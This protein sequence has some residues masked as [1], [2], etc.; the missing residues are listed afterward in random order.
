MMAPLFLGLD[1]GTQGTKGLLVDAERGEVVAR[2]SVAYGLIEGLAPGACEQHPDTWWAAV[3]GVVAA[4]FAGREGDRARVAGLGVSGQQHGLVALDEREC[5]L[6]PA[7]LWCDT[8]CAVE[9]REL[10]QRL[11]RPIPCG[12]TAPKILWLARHEPETFARTRAVCLPHEWINLRLTSARTAEAGDASGTGFFD[13]HT[14]T[15]DVS[16]ARAIDARVPDMLA[17]LVGADELAGRL[18][19]DAARALGL[20]VG[21]PVS[22]GSGDNMLSALGA[23]ATRPGVAVL[24]LG[25]SGTVCTYS[26]A[27]VI[28][29]T[30]AI[31][32]FCDATGAYLPLLCVMNA[33][34]VTE[35]VRRAFAIDH[36]A[37]A[38]AAETAPAGAR[39][40]LWLPYL[41]GERV[42]D[43][44]Q[45]SGVIAG[46]RTGTLEPGLL[47]RAAI[48]GVALNLA[49]G[50]ER[51]REQGVSIESARLVGGASRSDLWGRILAD[52]LEIP[53]V[54]PLESESAALGAAL[55]ALW[56]VRRAAGEELSAD[57]VAQ[58]FV[59]CEASATLPDPRVRSVYREASGRFR[60]WAVRAFG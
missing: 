60:E 38:C 2:A 9:A 24:S 17:P 30:G 15:Y 21:V 25:T 37:L 1:V 47:Y 19:P 48:E 54:R 28:D 35:E 5:V 55:Q 7:Q 34:G 51:M 58:T 32:P 4:L 3:C 43:W 23:G 57:S 26:P 14:R 49:W 8:T 39:G 44:P 36:A 45:A 6:R 22:A 53:L 16:A 10:S 46:L 52:V 20:A 42:P 33:T 12:Y 41:N 31:A 56:A 29:P 27:P 18:S 59:R 11:G 13:P 40:V 50:I